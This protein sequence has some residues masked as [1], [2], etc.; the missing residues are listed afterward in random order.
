MATN[1]ANP[2]KKGFQGVQAAIWIIVFCF[3]AAVAFYKFVLGNPANFVDGNPE[4][5]VKDDKKLLLRVEEDKLGLVYAI[6]KAKL[7]NSEDEKASYISF[8][9]RVATEIGLEKVE[10]WTQTV[11]IFLDMISKT[12]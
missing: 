2:K 5:A 11:D 12:E 9:R 7:Y 8:F 6:L 1:Q 4:N 10:E 3:I